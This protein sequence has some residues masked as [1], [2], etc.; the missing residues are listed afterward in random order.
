MA[1]FH[2]YLFISISLFLV[3]L[4]ASTSQ[5]TAQVKNGTYIGL[6]NDYYNVDYFLGMRFAQPPVGE[7][8]LALPASLNTSFSGVQNATE[9]GP[10]CIGFSVVL[11]PYKILHTYSNDRLVRLQRS[12]VQ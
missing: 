6:H 8:R 10:G 9:F 1:F 5:P 7:L 12:I 4:A 3:S 2:S 11:S